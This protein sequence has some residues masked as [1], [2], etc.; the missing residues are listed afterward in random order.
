MRLLQVFS[1]PRSGTNM[2]LAL[3]EKN[4]YPETDVSGGGA[5]G[6]W[7][8]RQQFA[9]PVPYTKL[10]GS[11]FIPSRLPA[12]PV[13]IFRDGRAVLYSIWKSK[14][15]LHP[16]DRDLSFSEFIRKPLD[17]RNSPSFSDHL[18][19]QTTPVE[20]WYNH[21]KSYQEHKERLKV[22]F[23]RYE[24]LVLDQEA[25]MRKLCEKF[26][27]TSEGDFV[28]L[29][30]MVGP[31]PNAGTVDAWKEGWTTEDLEYFHQTVPNNFIGLHNG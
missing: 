7:A 12:Y 15:F 23:V 16:K 19:D 2:L 30:N 17:W 5:W 31:T 27:Y 9:Q 14:F 21:V 29:K 3:L 8:D 18:S 20:Q 26:G 28:L 13:Y 4:F 11:H 6:H 1:Y 24:D 10:F 25:V 22:F